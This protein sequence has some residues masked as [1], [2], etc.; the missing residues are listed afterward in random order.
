MRHSSRCRFSALGGIYLGHISL[1]PNSNNVSMRHKSSVVGRR[2]YWWW[3]VGK[4]IAISNSTNKF[5]LLYGIYQRKMDR[6]LRVQLRIHRDLQHISIQL[7]L[8]TVTCVLLHY[9][10]DFL[11]CCK[12]KRKRAYEPFWLAPEKLGSITAFLCED[13]HLYRRK[14]RHS[15]V[16][17][18]KTS[19]GVRNDKWR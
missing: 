15:V 17:V 12:E 4:N 14:K 16:Y 10:I 2:G 6:K 3:I 9:R 11:R 7:F 19:R 13:S 1:S 18:R 5:S 8:C